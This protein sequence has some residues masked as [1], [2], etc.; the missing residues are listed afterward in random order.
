MDDFIEQ[1]NKAKALI[2]A[3]SGSSLNKEM[4]S[5]DLLSLTPEEAVTRV[6]TDL[7]GLE[8]AVIET[9]PTIHQALQ[10]CVLFQNLNAK[11]KG[12][13]SDTPKCLSS[14]LVCSADKCVSKSSG[15]WELYAV[16]KESMLFV[17]RACLIVIAC[18][19]LQEHKCG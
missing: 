18:S 17:L 8:L 1:S 5:Q 3:T 14:L 11:Y 13:S 16:S 9:M 15:N 2:Q 6:A 12:I 7:E 10:V 4:Q 19:V